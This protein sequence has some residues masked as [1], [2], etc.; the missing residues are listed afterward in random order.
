MVKL[1]KL[2]NKLKNGDNAPSMKLFDKKHEEEHVW[3]IRESGLGATAHIPNMHDTW[4]GWEDSAIPPEKEGDYLR[5]LKKLFHKYNYSA[6]VYGHFGQGCIHCRIPF[7][8]RTAEGLKNYRSFVEEAAD[9]VVSYNGSLSGEHGDGQSRG[10]L[11]VKMFGEDLINAF[12]EFKAAWDPDWKM[13]PGKIVLPYRLDENLRLGT[14]YSPNKPKTYFSYSS[15]HGDFSRATLRCVG[16]GKCRREGGG[17]MC[18]SYMVTHEEMHSTRGRAHLL[19]E[20]LRG[21]VIKGGWKDEHV[22]EALDLCLACKGCKNDCPV[23]VD[24]ATYKAEFLAHY[25]KGKIRPRYAYA[26]G[27]IY[28]GAKIGSAFPALTNFFTQTPGL[29]DIAKILAG[30]APQRKIPPFA[31]ITFRKWYNRNNKQRTGGKKVL[32]WP[33]T[34]NNNFHP[35]T[36]IAAKEVLE[37]AGY[38]VEIPRVSLCCGRP[39]YDY[40]MLNLA[41]SLLKQ[42]LNNLKPQIEAGIPLVGLEPSCIAVFRD[43]LTELFPND[44]DAKRLKNNSYLLSEFLIEKVENYKTPTIKRKAVVHGHCH[45]KAI[46]GMSDES[47]IL[48]KIGLDCE[49]LTSGCCGMA[50]AFGFEKEKYDVSVK[51]GERVLLPAVR[52]AEKETIIIA[53]GFSCRTQISELTKRK[54]LHLAEVLHMGLKNKEI[55]IPDEYPRTIMKE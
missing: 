39:L 33:D 1:K 20:M 16:V 48:N 27:L 26:F 34:F 25:Y 17:T 12:K 8:L 32:L 55:S 41:K 45:H 23:D 7:D 21:D 37:D 49:I 5:D 38:I 54:A 53:D 6:S 3:E 19:F 2:M 13:N 15:D 28:W 9:L 11:L 31:G 44:E 47:E 29:R 18:P 46:M 4:P 42:I 36:L 52:T 50:G 22:K 35:E 24:L 10:E 14:N 40:G 30:M 51:C 43:E